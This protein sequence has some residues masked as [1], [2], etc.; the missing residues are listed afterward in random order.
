MSTIIAQLRA[1]VSADTSNFDAGMRRANAGLGQF[2]RN[3]DKAS[4]ASKRFGG[5]LQVFAG[6]VLT[7]VSA[8]L[9]DAGKSALKF[10][11]DTA[12]AASDIAESTSKVGVLLGAS[13]KQATDFAETSAKSFGVSK[14]AALEYVGV[15]S[16]LMRSTGQ[17]QAASAQYSVQLVKTAADLASF[18]NTSIG[19]AL[20]ALRS[21]LVGESEPLRRFGVQLSASAIESEV[22][23]QGL[24]KSTKEINN[25]QKQ[26]AILSIIKRQTAAASGDFA[27]TADGAANSTR[28]LGARF[29]DLKAKVGE[30][31]APIKVRLIR[32]VTEF[33]DLLDKNQGKIRTFFRGVGDRI[34]DTVDTAK[35]LLT[36]FSSL[37]DSV[38]QTAGSTAKMI[39]AF[40]PLAVVASNVVGLIASFK[41]LKSVQATVATQN[42]AFQTLALGLEAKAAARVGQAAAGARSRGVDEATIDL[43]SS[44]AM[45]DA[46]R[47]AQAA[48]TAIKAEAE[49]A[50]VGIRQSAQVA[51]AAVR[52]EA[53]I[54]AGQFA[55]ARA[56][57]TTAFVSIGAALAPFAATI[58]IVVAGLVALGAGILIAKGMFEKA[59]I[60]IRRA[61]KPALVV[62][63]LTK[64][65]AAYKKEREK[66]PN[67]RANPK[68]D[69]SIAAKN[70]DR[71]NQLRNLGRSQANANIDSTRAEIER[72]QGVITQGDQDLAAILEQR[73]KLKQKIKDG[74]AKML[75]YSAKAR[76]VQLNSRLSDYDNAKA[77]LARQQ[78]RLKINEGSVAKLDAGD[79]KR[80]NDQAYLQGENDKRR[81][82]KEAAEAAA[83]AAREF[84]AQQAKEAAEAAKKARESQFKSLVADVLAQRTKLKQLTAANRSQLQSANLAEVGQKYDKIDVRSGSAGKLASE[85]LRLGES[86]KKAETAAA[87]KARVTSALSGIYDTVRTKVLLLRD[88]SVENAV[89]VEVFKR[90][91]ASLSEAEKDRIKGIIALQYEEKRLTTVEEQAKQVADEWRTKTDGL[92][93]A[94]HDAGIEL[95]KYRLH[96]EGV[97]DSSNP[98][99]LA[100]DRFKMPLEA[101]PLPLKL[102]IIALAGLN[103]QLSDL[104]AADQ[105]KKKIRELANE[106][107]SLISSGSE[108]SKF[109][110]AREGTDF[111]G[112]IDPTKLQRLREEFVALTNANQARGLERLRDRLRDMKIDIGEVK[113][114]TS[115]AR[116]AFEQFGT[117][118]DKLAPE[119]AA[120]VEKAGREFDRLKKR[121]KELE[122][123]RAVG[124][125]IR[126][127][128]R[129]A[130]EAALLQGQ[131]FF[132]ALGAL[133]KSAIAR[134][135]A[136]KAADG[137]ARQAEKW[138]EAVTGKKEGE[139]EGAGDGK[140]DVKSTYVAFSRALEDAKKSPTPV[141]VAN[142]AALSEAI[143]QSS[144]NNIA[145][146]MAQFM[147]QTG[148]MPRGAAAS[149]LP[150]FMSKSIFSYATGQI[151]GSEVGGI[152]D[153]ITSA[154]GSIFS[155][156]GFA[157]GG[158]PPL[159]RVSLVGERGP[160]LFVPNQRGT[161]YTHEASRRIMEGS[162]GSGTVENYNYN[163]PITFNDQADR[164]RIKAWN[165]Q[166]TER[167]LR[168]A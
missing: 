148:G 81:S 86:I 100:L 123:I 84:A 145:S 77:E 102:V 107:Q 112:G 95:E 105:H 157:N 111:E 113:F 88:A 104:Q 160:E 57:I 125:T 70:E 24:A 64:E 61:E 39:A 34:Q 98:A 114:A 5:A 83:R 27:R 168:L 41:Q 30:V 10:A 166:R 56:G 49:V 28:I 133:F 82:A 18:N 92:A 167:K 99:I 150:D 68:L 154:V 129:G 15:F 93:D 37:P 58:G 26:L 38:Q 20:D 79:K 159:G 161:I 127:T 120:E 65:E 149:G 50:R 63:P 156:L 67:A 126:E 139:E 47:D 85:Y 73:E 134:I 119:I 89:A 124:Q 12:D 142:G 76:L 54:V 137:I 152:V 155:G 72:L 6:N 59:Q 43:L 122:S 48:Q 19:D 14:S 31:T 106:Y 146:I 40:A 109:L 69:A 1:L 162:S 33:F 35:A 151:F 23:A 108:W 78:A 3:L 16:N 91:Y 103:R 110:L 144:G 165:R 141:I 80:L 44:G 42:T 55:A 71:Q 60:E 62:T 136:E 94:H 87:D 96:V 4:G 29:E 11:N 45:R 121:A 163:G 22:M 53:G 101:L 97:E 118:I 51:G 130:F 25:Q 153:G 13:A 90:S 158:M 21:G 17:A 32:I 128:F 2:E 138:L 115:E 9:I 164:N 135:I 74:T 66:N 116:I 46:R 7:S 147:P 8:R 52:A 36:V 117:S 75:P 132:Q 140:G 131:N 143:G